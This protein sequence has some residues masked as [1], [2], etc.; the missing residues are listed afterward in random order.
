MNLEKRKEKR[1]DI[2]TINMEDFCLLFLVT[3]N[4]DRPKLSQES[5]DEKK[6]IT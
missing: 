5:R 6:Q 2:Q 3:F 1:K 4:L